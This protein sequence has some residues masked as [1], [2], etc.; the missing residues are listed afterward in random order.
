MVAF[1]GT[2]VSNWDQ[3]GN[4]IRRVKPGSPVTITVV[5]D[6]KTLTLHTTLATVNGRSGGYLGIAPTVVF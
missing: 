2:P 6:G 5:R 3:L 4:A 1:D